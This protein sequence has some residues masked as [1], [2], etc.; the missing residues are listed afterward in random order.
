MS[1]IVNMT[2][3]RQ[4]SDTEQGIEILGEHELDAVSGGGIG[5]SITQV[6]DGIFKSRNGG[7]SKGG[8]GRA[9]GRL[10]WRPLAGV[11]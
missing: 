3:P 1:D 6:L 8:I 7:G 5:G 11:S 10:S 2:E 9:W 4:G